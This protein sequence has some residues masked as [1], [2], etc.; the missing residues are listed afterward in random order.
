MTLKVK[1]EYEITLYDAQHRPLDVDLDL[2]KA[3]CVFIRTNL[4]ILT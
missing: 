3:R 4:A 2:I 1:K